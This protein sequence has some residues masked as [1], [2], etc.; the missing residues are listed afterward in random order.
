VPSEDNSVADALSTVDSVMMPIIIDTEK[1]AQQQSIDEE[2]Q[3][4]LQSSS[5]N[6][7]LQKFFLPE[8]NSTF[9]CD[10]SQSNVQLFVPVTSS[11][12]TTW[13]MAHHI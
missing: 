5:S 3:P 2:L 9:Y 6:L 4:I 10:Y 12:L 7:K 11:K 13:Y 8:T 1:L